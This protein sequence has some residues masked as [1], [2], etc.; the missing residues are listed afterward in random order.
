MRWETV[1]FTVPDFYQGDTTIKGFM[2]PD[3]TVVVP[4]EIDLSAMVKTDITSGKITG[5]NANTIDD[6]IVFSLETEDD[7]ILSV[8]TS[9][10]LIRPFNDGSFFVLI[11]GEETDGIKFENKIL[12][13][14]YSAGTEKIEVYGSYVVPEFGTI[15]GFILA[16]SVVSIII[17]SK[18]HI[19]PHSLS[20]L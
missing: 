3:G 7:G 20:K 2:H 13:I 8:T 9:D 19:M 12:T 11:N 5:I 17:L 18:K 4:E 14:P 15:A 1:Y 10:F 6:S 16:A